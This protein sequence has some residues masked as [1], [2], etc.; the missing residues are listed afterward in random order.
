MADLAYNLS[1]AALKVVLRAFAQWEVVGRENAPPKG[2]LMVVSNH[3]SNIDPPLLACSIPRRLFFMAKKE[4]FTPILGPFLRAYGA[5]PLERDQRDVEAL[6]WARR[7]LER[8]G[9]VALFPEGHRNPYRGL[10]RCSPGVALLALKSQAPLLPVAITGTE[11]LGPLWRVAFP[12][13]RI[14]VRIGQPFTLPR[15]EGK[16]SRPLLDSLTDLIMSRVAALLPESYR[17][18]YASGAAPSPA[19]P[20]RRG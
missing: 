10:Q 3:L 1:N 4:L 14:R 9:V 6:L 8:D 20:E 17:G 19:Q 7:L 13:G 11:R 16:V 2:P 15:I 5:Y 12:T 18:I